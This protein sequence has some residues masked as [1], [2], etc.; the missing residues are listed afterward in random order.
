MANSGTA[1]LWRGVALVA[2]LGLACSSLGGVSELVEGDRIRAERVEVRDERGRTRIL[3]EVT[4]SGTPQVTLRG[5]RGEEAAVLTHE[6]LV[7]RNQHGAVTTRLY[8]GGLKLGDGAAIEETGEY[9]AI[10]AAGNGSS[11]VMLA[12]AG[13]SKY[14]AFTVRAAPDGSVLLRLA[15]GP[16]K[17]QVEIRVAHGETPRICLRDRH[18]VSRWSAPPG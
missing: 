7:L 14:T 6:G 9:F 4:K 3:M 11:L 10:E 13:N 16:E 5:R 15:G 17:G 2:L 1:R 18:G 12:G 8:G